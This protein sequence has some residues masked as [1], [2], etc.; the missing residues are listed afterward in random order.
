MQSQKMSKGNQHQ[1]CGPMEYHLSQ[2]VPPSLYENEAYPS[3]FRPRISRHVDVADA[4]CWEACDDFEHATGMKL[5]SDSVG[6][7]NP[8]GG[9]VNALWLPEAIPERLRTISYLSELLFRHDGKSENIFHFAARCSGIF[10]PQY[11]QTRP[12]LI[13]VIDLTDEAETPDQVYLTS[14]S[15]NPE[16]VSYSSALV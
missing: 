6:C 5:K 11:I 13:H 2:P 3:R 4:A 8:I 15:D 7:I 1:H 12:A 9:N 14:L 16:V 10:L